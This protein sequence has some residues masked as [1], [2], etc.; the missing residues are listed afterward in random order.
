MKTNNKL[1]VVSKTVKISHKGSDKIKSTVG[2]DDKP[3]PLEPLGTKQTWESVPGNTMVEK[4]ANIFFTMLNNK[5]SDF[6]YLFQTTDSF[7]VDNLA[8]IANAVQL[9]VAKQ[10][11]NLDSILFLITSTFNNTKESEQYWNSVIWTEQ[12]DSLFA[13]YKGEN[14]S[15]YANDIMTKGS[16]LINAN[17]LVD[18]DV[19]YV[20]DVV[21]QTIIFFAKTKLVASG[22]NYYSPIVFSLVRDAIFADQFYKLHKEHPNLK[23][24]S[25]PEGF[26]ITTEFRKTFFK[27]L[28]ASIGVDY[29]TISDFILKPSTKGIRSGFTSDYNHTDEIEPLLKKD[30]IKNLLI[31]GDPDYTDK[32]ET[33]PNLPAQSSLDLISKDTLE[34]QRT[35]RI[36]KVTNSDRM[37][38]GGKATPFG[39]RDVSKQSQGKRSEAINK[40]RTGGVEVK[41]EN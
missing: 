25:D 32:K 7:L 17:M 18:D 31:Y 12:K 26:K 8:D 15:G 4:I 6:R 23:Q 2:K 34:R 21:T 16:G 35:F 33:Q 20:F 36:K 3:P 38:S 27:V 22:S 24:L 5:A 30:A 14:Y 37:K 10:K 39:K 40:A 13:L 9:N 1:F 41:P 11:Y 28:L 19:R 29:G